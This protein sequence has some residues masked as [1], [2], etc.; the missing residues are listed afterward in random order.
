[1]MLQI[2]G[3][4]TGPQKS[5][6]GAPQGLFPK[7]MIHLGGDEVNT[8]CWTKTPSVAKWLQDHNMT[9]D[10]VSLCLCQVFWLSK[11]I[12]VFSWSAS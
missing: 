10:D 2:S 9:A 6:K 8:D 3:E 7:N 12:E 1:M 5:T 11:V 4:M